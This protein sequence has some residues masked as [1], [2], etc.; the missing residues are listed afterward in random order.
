MSCM[1]EFSK[2]ELARYDGKN[3][4]PAYVAYRGN[5]YDVSGCF[6]WKDGNHQVLHDAGADLT[7]AME[8]APHGGDVLGKFPLVGTL[9]YAE[10]RNS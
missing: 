4:S 3:G 5:V 8:E 9:R 10:K 1:K 7:D 6:L 2:E